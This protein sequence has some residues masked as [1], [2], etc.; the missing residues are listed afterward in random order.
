MLM[1]IGGRSTVEQLALTVLKRLINE[2]VSS[3]LSWL[4]RADKSRLGD[5]DCACAC[6]LGHDNDHDHRQR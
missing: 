1:L 5:A 3:C 6:D 4:V 2:T